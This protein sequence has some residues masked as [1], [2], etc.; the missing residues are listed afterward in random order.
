ME[1]TYLFSSPLGDIQAG[2]SDLK[3]PFKLSLSKEHEF[4][5][6]GDYFRCIE[7]FLCTVGLLPLSAL[8]KT[9]PSNKDEN[10][11]RPTL[12]RILIRT[13]KHGALYHMASADLFTDDEMARLCIASAISEAGKIY[14]DNEYELIQQLNRKTGLSY[15]PH[16]YVKAPV[17]CHC[18]GR[19]TEFIMTAYQWFDDFHE[20]HFSRDKTDGLAIRLWDTRR[21][22]RWLERNEA[23]QLFFEISFILTMYY[24]VETMRR[25]GPWHNGAGDF[26]VKT[27]KQPME[28]RLTTVRGYESL[29]YDTATDPFIGL[30]YFFLEHMIQIRM[31]RLD[32]TGEPVWAPKEYLESAV[33]GF[34]RAL[35]RKERNG[36]PLPASAHMIE[37]T[38]ADLDVGEIRRLYT[39]IEGEYRHGPEGQW[40]VIDQNLGTHVKELTTAIR[41]AYQRSPAC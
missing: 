18:H 40:K 35:E 13:E 15:L 25:I 6:L 41:Y 20:W 37:K 27:S 22:Y 33:T 7:N 32:G 34:F 9:L 26:I 10:K 38:L 3:K 30:I 16:P 5:T 31:D 23:L 8:F 17:T 24:D 28:V 39:P 1:S 11:K 21:G 36:S 29:F 14:L 12:K 4:L 19:C 2:P